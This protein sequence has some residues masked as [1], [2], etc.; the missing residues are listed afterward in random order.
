M[1]MVRQRTVWTTNL[2][3]LRPGPDWCRHRHEHTNI[4][5]IGGAVGT[6]MVTAVVYR[7]GSS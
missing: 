7:D 2:V 3:A 4:R 6:A 1:R 5:N